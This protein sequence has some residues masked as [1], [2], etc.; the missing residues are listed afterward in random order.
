M[1]IAKKDDLILLVKDTR[2][3]LEEGIKFYDYTD[4]EETAVSYEKYNGTYV[5]SEE[6]AALRE[7]EFKKDFFE[8]PNVGWYRKVPKGY[9][10]AVESMNTAFNNFSVM[11]KFGVEEFPADTLIFY[12]APDFTKPEECTEEWLVAHQFKNRA[13]TAQEFGTFYMTFTNAWNNQEHKASEVE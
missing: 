3:E 13:M 5:T 11:N 4:I 2:E 10:S 12:Q 9:S 6:A 1:W 7:E 8:V